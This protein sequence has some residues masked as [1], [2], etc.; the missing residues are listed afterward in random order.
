MFNYFGSKTRL[1]D[2]Y[3]RPAHDTIVEPFAGSASY[4]FRYWDRQVVLVEKDE[5]L[6]ALWRWLIDPATTSETIAAL[7]DVTKGDIVIDDGPEKTLVTLAAVTQGFADRTQVTE[8]MARDWPQLRR[9]A[10]RWVSRVKHWQIIEGDY[11]LAPDIEATWF[12]DPPYQNIKHGYG[13]TRDTINF[14][15]LGDWCKS[16]KG[17]VI[18]CEG[19]DADWLPF[20]P[21]TTIQTLNN[22]RQQEVVWLSEP[23]P[24]K[25]F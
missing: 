13:N 5:R 2:L 19:P 23:D 4:A 9:D 6:S 17:S 22:T 14:P 15:A 16:R 24:A 20:E 3:P 18:V 7:P 11:T 10:A 25:L 1:A 12:I 8:W 21:L